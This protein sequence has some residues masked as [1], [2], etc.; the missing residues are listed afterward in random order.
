MVDRSVKDVNEA[1]AEGSGSLNAPGPVDARDVKPVL[2]VDDD[3]VIRRLV[4]AGLEREGFTVR[5]ASDGDA[6]LE[7]LERCPAS[8]VI[9][10]VNLG[11]VG[12][13]DVLS[14]IRA[15][16]EVPV[17]LLTGRVSETDRVVGLELGADDYVVK[18]FSP[19]ELASRVRAV[20]RRTARTPTRVLDFGSLRIDLDARRVF[21][22]GD[23]VELTAREFDLLTFLASSPRR[24]FSRSFLLE[25][26]W[27]STEDW[28]D[29]A[30]VTEHVRRLR[31]KLEAESEQPRWIR[32][33]RA[34]GYAFE[35]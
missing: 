31:A 24:V 27:H 28:Q 10:D 13:F 33:V 23:L 8:L 1:V 25:Q 34:K 15:S 26:V 14:K 11:A 7:D 6:A 30:T 12:G 21:L 29:P 17:I 9:L 32:T 20:L 22:D 35:P 5:D 16:S 2:V 18:P 4:R 3:E 19:R